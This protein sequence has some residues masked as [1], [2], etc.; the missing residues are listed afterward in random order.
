[1]FT[2]F[3]VRTIARDVL[4]RCRD[5]NYAAGQC[6][7]PMSYEARLDVQLALTNLQDTLHYDEERRAKPEKAA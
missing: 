1:M 5:L 3:H 2:R 7:E 4:N 6:P